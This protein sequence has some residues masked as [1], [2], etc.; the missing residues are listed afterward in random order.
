MGRA[1]DIA[2]LLTTSSVLATDSEVA[3]LEYLTN[4]SAS[5]T[6]LTQSSASTTYAT[7]ANFSNTA[8]TSWTPVYT[9]L[10]VGNGTISARY[11]QIGK[12]V[13]IK[14]SF[15]FGSTSSISGNVTLT[16]PITAKS[17]SLYSSTMV[18]LTDADGSYSIGH[19]WHNGQTTMQIWGIQ[20]TGGNGTRIAW[21]GL[22]STFPHTWA[23]SDSINFV[24]TYEAE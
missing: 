1:R 4:A 19:V 21:S 6:Y 16:L 3:A 2:S 17:D 22:S 15:T 7:Q 20:S 24:Y 10:T 13:F 9:N 11:K 14:H 12:T 23:T 18:N 8:W 5:S